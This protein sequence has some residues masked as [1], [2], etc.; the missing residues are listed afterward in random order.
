MSTIIVKWWCHPLGV[1][2][3]KDIKS[4]PTI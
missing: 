4:C 2:R 3:S 1:A